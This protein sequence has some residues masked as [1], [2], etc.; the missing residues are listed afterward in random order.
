MNHW[1][2]TP[3]EAVT[4]VREHDGYRIHARFRFRTAILAMFL[5]EHNDG[6][7]EYYEYH[8][9]DDGSLEERYVARDQ[10]LDIRWRIEPARA[11]TRDRAAGA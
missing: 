11:N 4:L 3:G 9:R 8:F 2:L 5:I 7:L 6:K 10:F 1:D